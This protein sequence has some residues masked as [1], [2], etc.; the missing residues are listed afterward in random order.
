M[1]EKM[2][3]LGRKIGMTRIFAHN[4]TVVPVT[5]IKAGPCPVT[6]V[7]SVEKD[8]YSAIQIAF[9]ATKEKALSKPETGHTAKAGKGC[10]RTLREIRLA[11][12]AELSLGQDV[13]VDVFAPGDRVKV[14]GTTIGKGFQGV[15]RRWNYHGLKAS[16]GNEKVPR[17]GGA[18]GQCTRP[19][20][21]FKGKKMA[22]QWGNESATELN[23]LVVDVRPGDNVILIKGS[24]P[25]PRNGL[26]FI[27]K[28]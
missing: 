7:K 22:G 6:Q 11:G 19:G 20:R 16:H 18:I 15:M 23:L 14:S 17:S 28:Q 12:P 3:I 25:G 24:V 4:G 5:V 13:T 9:D 1:A 8:G 21:V 26:V 2:G 10:F 27:R